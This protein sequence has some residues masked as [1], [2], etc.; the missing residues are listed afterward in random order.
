VGVGREISTR[1]RR[2]EIREG[3]GKD[4]LRAL[5]LPGNPTWERGKLAVRVLVVVGEGNTLLVLVTLPCWFPKERLGYIYCFNVHLVNLS[6]LI[7]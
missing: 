2:P 4:M 6:E 1:E 7:N 3:V 5:E